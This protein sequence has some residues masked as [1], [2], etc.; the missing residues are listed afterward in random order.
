MALESDDYERFVQKA[1]NSQVGVDVYHQKEYEGRVSRR[2]IK[3][4][5]SFDCEV[6]GS[7]LLFLVECK[8][9]SHRVS[10]DDV[11]EFHSKIDD[12]GAQKGIMVTTV[13]Y[14]KGA[15]MTGEARGMALAL[16]TSE[17]QQ[18]ELR[19]VVNSI[20]PPP[21]RPPHDEFWQGNV[22]GI[23]ENYRGGLRFEDGGQFFGMLVMEGMHNQNR[24]EQADAG[25]P[26]PAAS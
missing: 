11:E 19:Y 18:G 20:S 6:A 23:L 14:Q 4:D 15:I 25:K 5:V 3:V 21:E 12:I 26:D 2:K 17:P 7:R 13:G 1:L 9:Y 10:V 24:S 16:L 22:K 8:H